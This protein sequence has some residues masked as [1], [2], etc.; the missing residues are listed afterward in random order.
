MHKWFSFYAKRH[1]W[2]TCLEII[3]YAFVK[4]LMLYGL[5]RW[6]QNRSHNRVRK[7]CMIMGQSSLWDLDLTAC[8][9]YQHVWPSP[10]GTTYLLTR[11]PTLIGW[12]CDNFVLCMSFMPSMPRRYLT[13]EIDTW[14]AALR[15]ID[16]VIGDSPAPFYWCY[17]YLDYDS[18]I[19]IR[20]LFLPQLTDVE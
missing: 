2:N 11:S 4:Q 10:S 15:Y 1:K 17:Q 6:S 7:K 8:L 9:V 14:F 5:G 3:C 20:G 13:H 19:Q 18:E 16:Y 12:R